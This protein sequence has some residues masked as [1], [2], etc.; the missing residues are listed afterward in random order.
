MGRANFVELVSVR[1]TNDTR[2]EPDETFM[3]SMS[4]PSSNAELSTSPQAEASL[5]VTTTVRSS[6][7]R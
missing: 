2:D 7:G 1:I 5:S 6:W 4:N 3:L